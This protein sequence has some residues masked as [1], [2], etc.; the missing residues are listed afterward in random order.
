MSKDIVSIPEFRGAEKYPD[1]IEHLLDNSSRI[2]SVVVRECFDPQSIDP[3]IERVGVR[4]ILPDYAIE[5]R[6]TDIL[7]GWWRT[8]GEKDT[9]VAGLSGSGIRYQKG[10]ASLG[11]CEGRSPVDLIACVRGALDVYTSAGDYILDD[12]RQYDAEM[13]SKA[14]SSAKVLA[15]KQRRDPSES[16]K[17]SLF[18]HHTKL[19]AGDVA[20]IMGDTIPANGSI[21]VDRRAGEGSEYV[22]YYNYSGKRNP[23]K[24]R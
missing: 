16:N 12:S 14:Q 9:L 4:M 3:T 5:E 8:N 1:A 10:V 20:L 19:Q 13:V 23:R 17:R 24:L 15:W 22:M 18:S 2:G 11:R 6:A 21:K 7:K